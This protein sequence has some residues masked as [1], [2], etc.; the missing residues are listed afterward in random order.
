ME[1]ADAQQTVTTLELFFDLVFVFALTQITV[2]M[3]STSPPTTENVLRGTLIVAVRWRR[4][5]ATT[6]APRSP[7]RTGDCPRRGTSPN[8]TG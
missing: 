7:A 2:W 6:W 4:C 5:S 1:A 8:G 3:A